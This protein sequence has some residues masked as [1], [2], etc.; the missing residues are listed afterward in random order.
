MGVIDLGEQLREQHPQFKTKNV[1][2]K[3]YLH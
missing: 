3:T 2:S 1:F